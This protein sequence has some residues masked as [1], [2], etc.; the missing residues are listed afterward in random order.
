M[1]LAY[2]EAYGVEEEEPDESTIK[3]VLGKSYNNVSQYSVDEQSLF[4]TYHQRFKLGSKPAAHID[5]LA[6]LSDKELIAKMPK[7]LNRLVDAVIAKLGELP[8]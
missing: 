7:S 2:P 5:A 8:E 6:K 4:V 1:L 3:A